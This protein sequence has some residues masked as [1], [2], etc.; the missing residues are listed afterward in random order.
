MKLGVSDDDLQQGEFMKGKQVFQN[1][2]WIIFCKIIQSLLQLIIGMITARYLGPSNYGLINYA[3]SVVSFVVPIM[4]LGLTS[5]LVQELI[6]DPQKEGE[7]LGTAVL[8]ELLSSTVCFL[9]VGMFVLVANRGEKTTILV[10]VL[11]CISLFVR[12]FEL[13]Q[14]WFQYKLLSKYPSLVCLGAYLIVSIYKIYILVTGKSIF[15]FAIVNSIDYFV[16]GIAL[17]IIYV[18]LGGQRLTF[19]QN[20]A[21]KIFSRSKY[22]I[23]ASMMVVVFQNTDHIML[24]LMSGDVENGYYT[25]AITSATVLQFVYTAIIE[26]ARPL[27]LSCKRQGLRDYEKNISRLYCIT[28]YMALIQSL[29]FT[30][31]AKIIVLI[32]YGRDYLPAV[33]VLQTLVWYSAFS[34]MGTVRNVWILAEEKQQYL[35]KVNLYGAIFNVIFNTLLIP[36]LGATGA[37]LASLLTQIFTN[38]VLGFI[39]KPLRE[40]NRLLTKGLNPRLLLEL[41]AP[42]IRRVRNYILCV[43]GRKVK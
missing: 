2:K 13:F 36:V 15:W 29:G 6:E 17:I 25:A 11:Y 3:S 39:I 38:F 19:S 31:F 22:Y 9:C 26:S 24:K 7:I 20:T 23:L 8:M 42:Y 4:Q 35:W 37:A 18:R 43:K 27:I 1:A 32:L 30:I 10:C 12:A 40:N 16:I 34:Y 5:T 41:V 33:P 14:C 28:I 21:R